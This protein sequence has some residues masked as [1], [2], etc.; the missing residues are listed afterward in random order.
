MTLIINFLEQHGHHIWDKTPLHLK[1]STAKIHVFIEYGDNRQKRVAEVSGADILDFC[2]WLKD[3]REI[4]ENTINHYRSALS[5]FFNYAK[6]YL[7]LPKV[8]T[9][10]FAKVKNQRVRFYNHSEIKQIRAYLANHQ[11]KWLLPMFIISITTGMRLSEMLRV[12]RDN[13]IYISDIR[14]VHLAETKNGDSR[15]VPLSNDAFAA[16]EALNWN[17]EAVFIRG[18]HDHAWATIRR[19]ICNG[20]KSAVFHC[21]RHTAATV[22]ANEMNIN[23][24]LIGAMLGH[25]DPSS[26]MKY[27]HTK[28]ETMWTCRVLVPPHVLV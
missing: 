4:S 15:D 11:R 9:I 12:R 27:V 23:H 6:D 17:G 22:M 18:V 5:K 24:L 19:D 25:K 13:V 20:D 28:P 8:P 7:D 1:A 14:H 26:A 10:K 3:A 21:T 2:H 16:F